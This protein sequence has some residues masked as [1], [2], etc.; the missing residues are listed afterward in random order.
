MRPEI[1]ENIWM[2]WWLVVAR[3]HF[4]C[5]IFIQNYPIPWAYIQFN[6][7]STMWNNFADTQFRRLFFFFSFLSSS[8]FVNNIKHNLIGV[9]WS[10]EDLLKLLQFSLL[11]TVCSVV[12]ILFIVSSSSIFIFIV[13][14]MWKWRRLKMVHFN[15]IEKFSYVLNV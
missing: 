15:G 10:I 3:L 8:S 5:N 1:H 6:I 11:W 13:I 9:N 14:E 2:W 7:I 4:H 12:N